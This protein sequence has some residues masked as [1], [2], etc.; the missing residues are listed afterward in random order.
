MHSDLGQLCT[1]KPIQGDAS[2][3]I[4]YLLWSSLKDSQGECW[5]FTIR[6]CKFGA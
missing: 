1:L 3:L 4:I 5:K 2:A 6:I